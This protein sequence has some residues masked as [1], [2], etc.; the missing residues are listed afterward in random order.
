[1]KLAINERQVTISKILEKH[2]GPARIRQMPLID[3]LN[4]GHEC[5]MATKNLPAFKANMNQLV[6]YTSERDKYENSFMDKSG[7]VVLKLATATA[8]TAIGFGVAAAF[9]P[10]EQLI[11]MAFGLTGACLTLGAVS[12]LLMSLHTTRYQLYLKR[13]GEYSQIR[14]QEI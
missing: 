10:T 9:K 6:K 14:R 1:M 4:V 11:T 5:V 2:D 13:V 12:L 3:R 8:V 7:W